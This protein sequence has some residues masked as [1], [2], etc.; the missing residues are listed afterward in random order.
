MSGA[1]TGHWPLIATSLLP[2]FRVLGLSWAHDRQA[3]LHLGDSCANE[4]C[5][6]SRSDAGRS[7][8]VVPLKGQGLYLVSS[9]FCRLEGWRHSWSN[10]GNLDC[11]TETACGGWQK[12]K[13]ANVPN[14]IGP[15]WLV[16]KYLPKP[17]HTREKCVLICL[18]LCYF[19]ICYSKCLLIQWER[20]FCA[21]VKSDT[22]IH[23]GNHLMRWL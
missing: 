7:F 17:C 20:V 18:S 1:E 5:D 13:R 21:L 9:P 6:V 14:T 19:S 23:H 3:L 4:F 11:K 12:V 10:S 15:M 2:S 22:S 16:M 8:G